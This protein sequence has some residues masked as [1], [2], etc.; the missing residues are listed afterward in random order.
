MPNGDNNVNNDQFGHYIAGL[1]E[2]DGSIK[3]P[4]QLRSEKGKLLTAS[5]NIVFVY[6]DLQLEKVMA[7]NLQ[8]TI[9]KAHGD[10]YVL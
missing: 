2:G 1:I 6:K 5:V 4:D 8:G 3:V 10:Y 9:N 7:E